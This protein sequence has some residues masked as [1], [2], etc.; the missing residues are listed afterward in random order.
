[1]FPSGVTAWAGFRQEPLEVFR[2]DFGDQPRRAR[3]NAP[4]CGTSTSRPSP[5]SSVSA[6]FSKTGITEGLEEVLD[7]QV[8]LAISFSP[9]CENGIRSA[10]DRTVDHS[11]EM[12]A[13]ERKLRIGY[14]VN[15]VLA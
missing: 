12:H 4:C 1:M 3:T 8:E 5:S 14:R 2:F 7:V 10:F 6:H 13:E 9:E 15:E 11:C